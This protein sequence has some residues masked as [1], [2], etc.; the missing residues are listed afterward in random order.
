M[1]DILGYLAAI[2]T[3]CAFVPQVVK[4]WRTRS[5]HDLSIWWLLLFITG[6]GCW[7]AYSVRLGVMPMMLGNGVTL[8]LALV[9]LV[10]KITD[11]SR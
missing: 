11:R 2:L 8:S 7:L 6:V 9:L 1:T 10:L 4:T 3:T 5:A